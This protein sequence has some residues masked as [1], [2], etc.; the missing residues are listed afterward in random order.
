MVHEKMLGCVEQCLTGNVFIRMKIME[1]LNEAKIQLFQS[2][3]P[4]YNIFYYEGAISIEGMHFSP[5]KRD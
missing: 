5:A 4:Y 1:F 3:I 2:L